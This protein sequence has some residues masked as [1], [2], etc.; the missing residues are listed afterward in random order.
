[1][2]VSEVFFRDQL[3]SRVKMADQC[4]VKPDLAYLFLAKYAEESVRSIVKRMGEG[5]TFLTF[6]PPNRYFI[7]T[8][9]S[10]MYPEDEVIIFSHSLMWEEIDKGID[11]HRIRLLVESLWR[12]SGYTAE[13]GSK[14]SRVSLFMKEMGKGFIRVEV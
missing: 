4:K 2:E 11:Y 6:I 12:E 13:E 8:Q 10:Q 7:L 14:R 3:L 1:M 9:L 5:E